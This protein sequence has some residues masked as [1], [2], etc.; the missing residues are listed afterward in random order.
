MRVGTGVGGMGSSQET[1]AVSW[2]RPDATWD[3]E[4]GRQGQEFESY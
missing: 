1:K 2:V 3:E 4:G